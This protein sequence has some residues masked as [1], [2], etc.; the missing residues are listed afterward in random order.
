M[1]DEKKGIT[2][3]IDAA[4]HAEV[5]EYLESHGM[6]M[7]EFVTQALDN[8]LHP[9]YQM[10]EMQM[11][12]NA[13]TIAFQV[14][15]ELYQ[16]IKDYLTRNNMTQKQFFLGLVETELER[17]QQAVNAAALEAQDADT[18]G[19]SENYTEDVPDAPAH[20]E[21]SPDQDEAPAY[22]GEDSPDIGLSM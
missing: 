9:K 20:N 7:A 18:P 5:R 10:K 4:L 22:D 15:E 12:A 13:R 1:P 3:K 11:M 8:E 19:E 2:V 17:E 6:T 16:R 21:D 14:P